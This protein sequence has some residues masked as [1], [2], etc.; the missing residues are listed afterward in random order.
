MIFSYPRA[1]RPE[2]ASLN[3]RYTLPVFHEQITARATRQK[4]IESFYF[5]KNI[6]SKEI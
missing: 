6:I 3:R 2:V 4:P 5:D 1:L